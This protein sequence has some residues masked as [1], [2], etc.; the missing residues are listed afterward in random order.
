VV[1]TTIFAIVLSAAY[2]LFESSR[3]VSSRAELRARLFQTARAAL[4]AVEEDLRGAFLSA[5]AFDAE[6]VSTNRATGDLPLDKL[7][8]VAVNAHPP[9]R[10][11][12]RIDLTRVT[13][14]VDEEAST[15][16]RERET[17]LTTP[18]RTTGRPENIEDVAPDVVGLDFR[19]YDTAWQDAWD[20][21]TQNRLPKAIE[22]SVVVRGMLR[23]EPLLERFQARFYLPLGA[24]TPE[25]QPQ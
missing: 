16:I 24:E 4:R 12:I 2:A 9:S 22:V 14:S 5:S 20:S 13:Y 15:L 7:E 23:D 18:S 21:T 1:A 6:L 11:D 3:T 8:I 19:F 25:R 17:A 10:D